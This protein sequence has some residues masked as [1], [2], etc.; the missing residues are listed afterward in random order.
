MT[1]KEPHPFSERKSPAQARVTTLSPG[2][3]ALGS[4]GSE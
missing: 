1:E 4:E 3:A 2:L